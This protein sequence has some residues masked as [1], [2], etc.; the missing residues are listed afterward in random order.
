MKNRNFKSC[1]FNADNA[2]LILLP[3]SGTERLT[4]RT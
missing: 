2:A 4:P 3:N 1:C